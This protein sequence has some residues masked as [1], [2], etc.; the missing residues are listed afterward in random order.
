MNV[1]RETLTIRQQGGPEVTVPL[2]ALD[3][4]AGR[5]CPCKLR[6]DSLPTPEV[7]STVMQ[8]TMPTLREAD[9]APEG[10][11]QRQPRRK[12]PAEQPKA[13][14]EDSAKAAGQG[15][16]QRSKERGPKPKQAA[17]PSEAQPSGSSGRRRRRRRPRAEGGSTTT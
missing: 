9:R 15:Q 10:A 5:G 16:K 11:Q 8:G 6:A 1:P 3:C 12:K 4:S 2:E 13:A 14:K 7:A 17:A